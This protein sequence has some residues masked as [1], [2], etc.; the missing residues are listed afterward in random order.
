MIEPR[1]PLGTPAQRQR[2]RIVS[3]D[4]RQVVTVS[5]RL[6][7]KLVDSGWS[8]VGTEPRSQIGRKPE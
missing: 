4:G 2:V 1:S 8:L 6:A 3:P 7:D 5:Q